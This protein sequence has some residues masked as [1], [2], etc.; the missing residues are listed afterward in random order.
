MVL[1]DGGTVHLRPIRPDD[2]ARLAAFHERQSSESIYFRF[3]SPRPRL[4][5]RDLERFTNVDHFDHMAFVALLGDEMVGMAGYDRHQGSAEA[6]VAF[7]VD[8]GHQKRG[9]ATVMLEYLAEAAREIGLEAFTAQVLPNNRK[10]LRVF[11]RA[12]FD[13][14][15][16]FEEGV[17]EVHLDLAPTP[18]VLAAIADRQLRSEVRSVGRLL[19]PRSVAVVGASTDPL[20]IGHRTLRNLLDHGFAGPVYPVNRTASHV[21]SIRAYP[22]VLDIP[23]LV[24]LVMI[25]VPAAEVPGV[26]DR[27][28][29]KRVRAVVVVS[30]GFDPDG[31]GREL[32]ERARSCGMRLLGPSAM[33]VVNTRPGVWMAA[34][35]VGPVE[36]EAGRA[37]VLSQ[38]GSLGLAI[39]GHAHRLGVGVSTFVGPGDRADVSTNDLLRY[40]EQDDRT[41]VVL[42]YQESFGNP[43]NFNRIAR[44]VCRRKPVVMVRS[45]SGLPVRP[46]EGVAWP[47]EATVGALL[48]QAGVIRVDT[49]REL[50]DVGRILL[51]QPLPRGRRVAVVANSTGP[52]RLAA[53]A[54]V[55]AGLQLV[56]EP[57]DLTF[58]AGPADFEGAVRS[59]ATDHGAD[60]IVVI[61]APPVPGGGDDVARAVAAAAAEHPDL[62][63]VATFLGRPAG[64]LATSGNRALGFYA[65]PEEAVRALGRVAEYAEWRRQ[66][67]GTAVELS[68][69][70]PDGARRLAAAAL[71]SR[72]RDGS[73]VPAEADELLATFG[74]TR[75]VTRRAEGVEQLV[76]AAA[77]IGYP[78]VLKATGLA[79]LSKSET[80][81]VALD[82]HDESELRAAHERMSELLGQAMVPAE[83]QAMVP[84]GLA[85]IRIAAHQ[86]PSFGAVISLA[87]GGALRS[88]DPHPPIRVLPLTDRDAAALVAASRIPAVLGVGDEAPSRAATAHLVDLLIRVA[89]LVEA[90]PELAV[91]VLD[92]VVLTAQGAAVTAAEVRVA[93]WRWDDRPAVRRVGE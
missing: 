46:S 8:D 56:G 47:P 31:E 10:M 76:A 16:S 57:I 11:Q 72:P 82:V 9:I 65:F 68:G 75:P 7:I 93:P 69:V 42:V 5:E 14:E 61:H 19:E 33:G 35:A 13:V 85:D 55:D 36:V 74:L 54:C 53:D 64:Q 28:A 67:E 38:S 4:S 40:W 91:L 43:T 92:P 21:A 1:A 81:G 44:R 25:C 51:H 22:D 34:L 59:L 41:D 15:S 39:L 77:T 45:A 78:V 73:L 23:D 29:Q 3:F 12:G 87:V 18:E 80:G 70:D 26:I 32:V 84:G 62:V 30:A 17:I 71:A 86:H 58:R 24:D 88:T 48:S 27:C 50:F 89:G 20:S 83:V 2:A 49:I 79:V 37:A 6:E 52:A 60:A 66:P 90:V 63:V